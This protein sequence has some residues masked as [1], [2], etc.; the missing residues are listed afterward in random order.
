MKRIL[1]YTLLLIS[2]LPLKAQQTEKDE[3]KTL[4]SV[5]IK[6]FVD[7]EFDKSTETRLK[8]LDRIK[9][10]H[11]ERDTLYIDGLIQLGKCYFR[12]K[13]THKAVE[14]AQKVVDLYGQNISKN[15]KKYA[16][17]LDNLSLY[18]ASAGKHQE[19]YNNSKQA[20]QIYEGLYTHDHDLAIILIHAAE[21]A[22]LTDDQTNAIKYE[23]RALT[24][25]KDLYGEHS[26]HY[27]EEAP[28][29]TKYYE[30]AKEQDKADKWIKQ[31]DKLKAEAEEGVGDLPEP[32]E[33]KTVEECRQHAKDALRCCE[34]YLSHRLT[35]KDI[36][37][38]AQYIMS[39]SETTDMV[40][41]MFG[42]NEAKLLEKEKS[43][44]YGASYLAGCCQYAINNKQ[45]DFTLDMFMHAM[46][47]TINYY[48]ANKDLTGEVPYLEKYVKL[49]KKEPDK[50]FELLKKNFPGTVTTEM[51]ERI[52][53]GEKIKVEK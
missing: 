15:D 41:I 26:K 53:N 27:L 47:A 34:F 9:S 49:Y 7:K 18:L 2:A 8:Y 45:A 38:A 48:V 32:M 5:A 22:N 33:F 21:N 14:T 35:A 39:W 52:K 37:D 29:L 40:H 6:Q 20:L 12:N 23:I 24:I 36:N 50:M 30:A 42:K 11:G 43:I 31:I 10:L 44:P 51:T 13:R 1:F 28:Y 4:D 16:W 17:Y 25:L 19:A 3:I 46:I